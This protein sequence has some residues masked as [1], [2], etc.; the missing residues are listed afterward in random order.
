MGMLGYSGGVI[1]LVGVSKCGILVSLF[2]RLPD[3]VVSGARK[4][5]RNVSA[6][7]LF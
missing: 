1:K 6:N 4:C 7:F 3:R 2:G 5:A